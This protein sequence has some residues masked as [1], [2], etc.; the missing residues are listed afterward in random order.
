MLY[1]FII[2]LSPM[3]LPRLIMTVDLY[4]YELICKFAQM[5]HSPKEYVKYYTLFFYCE[6]CFKV[7]TAK[8]EVTANT[9]GTICSI[10]CIVTLAN[11]IEQCSIFRTYDEY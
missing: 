5:E 4:E 1:M 11:C 7:K 9:D 10:S 8:N 6:Y 3:V 2:T